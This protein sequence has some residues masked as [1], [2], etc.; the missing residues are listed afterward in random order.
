M[1][2]LIGL[3]RKKNFM[4]LNAVKWFVEVISNKRNMVIKD[5]YIKKSLDALTTH[6]GEVIV[7]TLVI[8]R[9]LLELSSNIVSQVKN[10]RPS[11]RGFRSRD[12][13]GDLAA[14]ETNLDGVKK[15][16]AEADLVKMLYEKL[17]SCK[18]FVQKSNHTEGS[19]NLLAVV[20]SEGCTYSFVVKNMLAVLKWLILNQLLFDWL[21]E[22]SVSAIKPSTLTALL[23]NFCSIPA[24]RLT[25]DGLKCLCHLM[26]SNDDHGARD[27][28]LFD[29]LT[30]F[31]VSA[32]KPS[33]LTALL[34][35]FCSIPANRLTLDG[36][37]CLCHL[38]DSNDDHGARDE[39][40]AGCVEYMWEVLEVSE[41]EEIVST[42]MQKHIEM[43]SRDN[44]CLQYRMFLSS[45]YTRL[46]KLRTYVS[47]CF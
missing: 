32:I 9:E 20:L 28:L 3:A 45:C 24:N 22:F 27:E 21:T 26:D 31:S 23:H 11:S 6:S 38:M 15:L 34:H 44:E 18:D 43:G 2:N 13:W 16:V 4:T 35:N 25:L 17:S 29:W 46:D 42:V 41:D 40:S 12:L 33:T 19:D 30:E 39:A 7:S 37:K 1:W 10:T 14:L 8:L 36:L 47:Y 5:D